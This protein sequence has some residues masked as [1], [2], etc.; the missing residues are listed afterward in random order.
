M[1]PSVFCLTR[2]KFEVHTRAGVRRPLIV[3]GF[4][5]SGESER[6]SLIDDSIKVS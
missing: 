2:H 5:A 1:L 3:Y 4:V 6:Q